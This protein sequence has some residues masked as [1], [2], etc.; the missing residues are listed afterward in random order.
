MWIGVRQ[1]FGRFH[2]ALMLT[3]EEQ[4][5]G[6][7]KQHGVR[8]SLER[9]YYDRSTEFPPGFIVGSWG[10][11]TAVRPPTDIDVFFELPPAI[12][13][14]FEAY[15]GNKQSALLQEVRDHLLTTYPQTTMRGDGQVVMVQF[16]TLTVEVVPAFRFDNQGRFIM[17]DTNDGG[18]WKLVDPAEEVNRIVVA[19]NASNGNTRS[20]AQMLKVWKRECNVPLKSYQIE[21]LTADFMLQYAYREYDYYW[22]D[23]YFRDFFAFLCGKA[24]ASLVIPGTQEVVNLGDAWLSRAQTARDRALLPCPYEYI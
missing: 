12:Y 4:E 8:K 20:V 6:L 5:D 1:R 23:W 19:D 10:K 17:P 21:L 11:G 22:Y 2:R 7:R 3:T 18:R 14:R 13:H 24:W 9:A 15:T 16:N